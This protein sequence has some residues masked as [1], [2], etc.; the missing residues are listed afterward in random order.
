MGS[1]LKRVSVKDKL[2]H[3]FI[4][5]TALSLLLMLLS[6]VLISWLGHNAIQVSKVNAPTVHYSEKLLGSIYE[7]ELSLLNWVTLSEEKQKNKREAIWRK[8]IVPTLEALKKIGRD[9]EGNDQRFLSK[10]EKLIYALEAAQLRALN[11]I[12][13]I[14]NNTPERLNKAKKIIENEATPIIEQI[15]DKMTLINTSQLTQMESKA[16]MVKILNWISI[17]GL[18]LFMI[19]SGVFAYNNLKKLVRT[20]VLPTNKLMKAVQS[21]NSGDYD[22]QVEVISNDEIGLL[23]T[24]FNQMTVNLRENAELLAQN[25]AKS[26][27]IIDTAADGIVTMDGAKLIQSFNRAAELLF[28]YKEEEIKGKNIN[29][30]LS[31]EFVQNQDGSTDNSNKTGNSAM[32][33][34]DHKV[35]ARKKDGTIF[36]INISITEVR[37]EDKLILTGIM[38]DL[39]EETRQQ[40]E[41]EKRTRE[42][43]KQNWIKTAI[44]QVYE[45]TKE[46]QDV[47]A[48]TVILSGVISKLLEASV[49]TFYLNQNLFVSE[50]DELKLY[51]SYAF[52]NTT[53]LPNSFKFGEGLIGQCALEGNTIVIADVP[54]DYL[55][56]NSGAGKTKPKEITI[57]PIK[58]NK[59]II[60]VMEFGTTTGFN[61][62]QQEFIEEI[63]SSIGI[64]IKGVVE[65]G[66]TEELSIEINNQISAINR[67]NAAIEFDLD[68]N[69]LTANDLFLDL[70]GYTLDEIKG[71]HHKIFVGNTYAKSNEYKNF[72]K[73]LKQGA[74]KQGEFERRGKEGKSVWIQG[75]YNPILDVEGQPYKVLKVAVDITKQKEQQIKTEELSV[76]VNNQISAINRSNAAI[77]FDLDG[78]VLTANDLFLDLMG[79]TLDEIKGKHHKIFVG[80]T[81]AGSSEYKGFW[82]GLKNGEFKQ[83]EFERRRK[84]R[85]P[86]WIQGSYNPILDMEGQPYKVLKIA[87]DITEQKEI[88]FQVQKQKEI[89]EA[90]EEELRVSNEELTK[91]ANQLQASEEELRQQQEELEKANVL[92]EEKAQQLEEQHLFTVE[93]NAALEQAQ[94][95]L[96]LKSEELEKSGR[97]KSEFLANM[98]HELRTPLNSVIILSKLL[99]GNKTDNLTEKQIEFAQII[100]K[101]GEDLLSL[102]NEVLDLA[103][104]ESGKIELEMETQDLRA[105]AEESKKTFI[106]I[107]QDKGVDFVLNIDESLP[108]TFITDEQRLNQVVKNLLSNAFK[109]TDSEGTVTLEFKNSK[110]LSKFTSPALLKQEQVLQ[111]A[112]TDTGI[113]IAE[114]KLGSVFE[115]FVQEDGST[116]RKYGGTGLGLSISKELVRLLGGEI[117][118]ES[119]IGEGSTFTLFLPFDSSEVVEQGPSMEKAAEEARMPLEEETK[120]VVE[121]DGVDRPE[122]TN[123]KKRVSSKKLEAV[124]ADDRDQLQEGD[125]T[126][127]V[128]EDDLQF[129]K[130]LLDQARENGFKVLV[131]NQGDTALQ[132]VEEYRP[133]AIILDMQLPVMDGWTVLKKLKASEAHAHIP[134]HIISG[135]DKTKLG[136]ELGAVEYL[137]KPIALDIL[138]Q[139][140][141]NISRTIAGTGV[142]KVLIIEDDELNNK[143]L[144]EMIKSK[145]LEAVAAKNAKDAR[146]LFKNEHPDLVVLDL[147]LPDI[148]GIELLSELKMQKKEVPV[149]VFTGRELTKKELKQIERHKD[150]SVVLKTTKSFDRLSEETELF[151]NMLNSTQTDY[152]VL[153]PKEFD[154][155]DI[156][157]GKRILIVDD[158]MRNIYALETVL[159]E[160][161]VAVTIA[162]NGAEAVDE[163]KNGEFDAVLMDIMMPVMDGYEATKKIR[164]MGHDKLPIIALTAKAM[165]GDREKCLE[166]GVSD[167]MSKPL[168]VE[169]LLSL[170]RVWLYN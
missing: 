58:H 142:K 125:S 4:W 9:W 79:Y 160:E 22:K 155:D 143:A 17:I 42:I 77:E 166:A 141:S 117:F 66:K 21:V 109:F 126:L 119:T 27:A 86:V 134:V 10:T 82:K 50:S 113:G 7:S 43:E 75:S 60:G 120:P 84:D 13:N 161:Q 170:L 55:E 87:V 104:V 145:H 19:I 48:L 2:N 162:T 63:S 146:R 16:T 14:T 139:T 71:K 25:E 130:V 83:G 111:I 132:H 3:S 137:V 47:T 107:A 1:T 64:I 114:E 52:K 69:I 156:I 20:I 85:K 72:W 165:K 159:E 150:T 59:E 12:G 123:V 153:P 53:R 32:I 147:G 154:S 46:V 148:D 149:I 38:R 11:S 6:L 37:V 73:E 140:F 68:G 168:D 81:Y 158:D 56:I 167:Y 100:N 127:L 34:M 116:Q 99:Q 30:L 89:V 33:G 144:Q 102:I 103:K 169:K 28:Q 157:K 129:A 151:L 18:L 26:R 112:V 15:R 98:S 96:V 163:V 118:V 36:H 164:E 94:A 35:L 67:S 122:I 70:M 74:F 101:S 65:R 91:Q 128:V 61:G 29:V 31:D 131:A 92:L 41:L 54:G 45:A 78:H 152:P 136:L 90:Q 24:S 51:G 121:I 88:Q 62:A 80:K 40:E 44:S 135:I 23:S 8:D 95:A 39:S 76:E 124:I 93:K 133:N 105:Y 57:I 49:G 115:A 138:E 5:T 106:A 110:A 97:Y 108:E